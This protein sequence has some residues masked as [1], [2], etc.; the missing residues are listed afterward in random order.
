MTSHDSMTSYSWRH[1]IQSRRIRKLRPGTV[2]TRH[3]GV[4]T[5]FA[6]WP[7]FDLLE[8]RQV[9]WSRRLAWNMW[10]DPIWK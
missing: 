8:P 2:W 9:D 4:I 6:I 7:D 1:N 10:L 3:M 5:H